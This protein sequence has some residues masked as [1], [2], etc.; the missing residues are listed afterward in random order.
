MRLT[1]KKIKEILSKYKQSFIEMEHYDRTREILWKKKRINIIL[2]QRT[3][4]RLKELKAKSGK[5]ISQIIE[6]SVQKTNFT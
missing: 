6:E 4:N 2:A 1:E 5:P 3:I